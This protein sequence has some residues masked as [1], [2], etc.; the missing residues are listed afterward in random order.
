MPSVPFEIIS[1]V[2]SFV[3]SSS[4]PP[5]PVSNPDAP[6][7]SPVSFSPVSN[8]DAPPPPSLIVY[9]VSNPDA[10]P[11][12]PVSFS[13]V[14]NPDAPPPPSLIVY[15]V[16]NPDAPPPSPVSF[17]PVSNPVAP[18]YGSGGRVVCAVVEF[19]TP[20]GGISLPTIRTA[21][22]YCTSTLAAAPGQRFE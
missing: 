2:S 11:P 19:D 3:G 7:P 5:S 6:P 13:P 18:P 8:P 16:S 1:I 22:H 17:S 12:S 15:P 20:V 21:G 10:P 14:S 9:P 4:P